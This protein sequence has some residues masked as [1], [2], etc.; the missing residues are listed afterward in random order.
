ML[1]QNITS[2]NI[3]FAV[4]A[5]FFNNQRIKKVYLDH[6][7][8]FHVVVLV[9]GLFHMD[10]DKKEADEAYCACMLSPIQPFLRFI[11]LLIFFLYAQ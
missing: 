1:L 2:K 11:C 5:S 3:L 4:G 8:F 6:F 9:M 7:C 10:M